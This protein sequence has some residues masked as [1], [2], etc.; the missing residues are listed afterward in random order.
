MDRRQTARTTSNS[1][2]P[3]ASIGTPRPAM[4]EAFEFV[5]MDNAA[6]VNPRNKLP[7][8]PRNTLAGTKL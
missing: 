6:S 4:N 7:A 3:T 8:S 5:E 1:G 2:T